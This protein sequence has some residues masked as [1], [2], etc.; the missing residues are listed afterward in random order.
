MLCQLLQPFRRCP[1]CGGA[2]APNLRHHF[3]VDEVHHALQLFANS[4]RSRVPASTT[5]SSHGR[6][7]PFSGIATPA[8][9]IR[10]PH[11]QVNDLLPHSAKLVTAHCHSSTASLRELCPTS[12]TLRQGSCLCLFVQARVP[13][14]KNAHPRKDTL[15]RGFTFIH[16]TYTKVDTVNKIQPQTAEKRLLERAPLPAGQA[17]R[18]SR[19]SW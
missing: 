6:F 2:I 4:S 19:P 18:L 8:S 7:G 10:G 13:L 12:R 16:W 1:Q 11:A 5:R 15:L 14:H 17:C 9:M 3:G